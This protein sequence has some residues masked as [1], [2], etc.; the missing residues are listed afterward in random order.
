MCN[1]RYGFRIRLL[2]QCHRC[3]WRQ[4]KI[5]DNRITGGSNNSSWIEQCLSWWETVFFF[6]IDRFIWCDCNSFIETQ[7]RTVMPICIDIGQNGYEKLWF[8]PF[9]WQRPSQ[10]LTELYVKMT[11]SMNAIRL[12]IDVKMFMFLPIQCLRWMEYRPNLSLEIVAGSFHSVFRILKIVS[13]A[14]D[15]SIA[16]ALISGCVIFK[17]HHTYVLFHDR[18]Q[19]SQNNQPN[20]TWSLRG[21]CSLFLIIMRSNDDDQS[22][23]YK[24]F[25]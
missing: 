12:K 1:V 21:F 17:V 7:A 25:L 24:N 13:I 19:Q 16:Q 3:S 6:L 9:I 22:E 10:W 20:E 14:H 18:S 11:K 5:V 2:N 15:F 4:R 23:K 8:E